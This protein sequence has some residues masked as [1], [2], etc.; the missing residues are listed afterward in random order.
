MS[1]SQKGA[2]GDGTHEGIRAAFFRY[3]VNADA[4]NRQSDKI[5]QALMD[6]LVEDYKTMPRKEFFA[7]K[8]RGMDIFFIKYVVSEDF[9]INL[10]GTVSTLGCCLFWTYTESNQSICVS[11]PSSNYSTIACLA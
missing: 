2:G 1:L 6:Q 5:G 4:T 3:F 11:I 7:S 10:V 9:C 8:D